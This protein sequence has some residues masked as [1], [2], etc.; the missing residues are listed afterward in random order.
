M[1]DGKSEESFFIYVRSIGKLIRGMWM[2][3]NYDA[4]IDP[5]INVFIQ[6]PTEKTIFV[7]VRR[8]L[9][10]FA[11]TTTVPG[12]YKI[13]FSNLKHEKSK[14]VTFSFYNQE[15]KERD[16]RQQKKE[17]ESLLK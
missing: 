13:I 2:V 8:S 14:D 3:N 1:I 9:G 10:H 6:D 7:K 17:Q 11:L 12:E 15:E 4:N 5:V 16:E